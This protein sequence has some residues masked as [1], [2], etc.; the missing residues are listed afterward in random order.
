MTDIHPKTSST[1]AAAAN[2]VRCAL[3]AAATAVLQLLIDAI[4]VGWCFTLIG[5]ISG[6]CIPLLYIERRIGIKWRISRERVVE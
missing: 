5:A 2:I 6:L 1:A 3:A 4:G